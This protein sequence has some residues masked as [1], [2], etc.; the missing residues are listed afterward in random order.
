MQAALYAWRENR[1]AQIIQIKLVRKQQTFCHGE[2]SIHKTM[3]QQHTARAFF[4]A[5]ITCGRKAN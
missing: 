1:K 3:H 4:D 5:R 2:K